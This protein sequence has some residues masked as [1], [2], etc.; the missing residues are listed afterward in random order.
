MLDIILFGKGDSGSFCDWSFIW[1]R[2]AWGCDA[3]VYE[4]FHAIKDMRCFTE[5]VTK[6]DSVITVDELFVNSQ[7]T[8]V[9]AIPEI[10]R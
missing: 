10:L 6:D 1:G 8:T 7:L 2:Y 5:N 3:D 9:F 4:H